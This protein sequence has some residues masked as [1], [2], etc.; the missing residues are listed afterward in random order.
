LIKYLAPELQ[1]TLKR[2]LKSSIFEHFGQKKYIGLCQKSKTRLL[3]NEN[4]YDNDDN[5]DNDYG[6][7]AHTS[8]SKLPDTLTM[9]I[10]N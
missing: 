6:A 1:F 9:D 4:E 2:E 8:Y 10:S 5:D 3:F 7:N